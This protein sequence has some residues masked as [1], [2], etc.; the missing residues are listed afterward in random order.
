MAD[1]F[2]MAVQARS[3]SVLAS[4]HASSPDAGI[5]RRAVSA[6]KVFIGKAGRFVGQQ[7]VQLHGGMGMT[8]ELIV[9]HYFKR[10]TIINATFGDGDHHLGIFSDQI[11]A[12]HA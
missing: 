11:L 10:L 1:M 12:S 7:A 6:A 5:R 4:G 3:M 2:I 8:A 9:S